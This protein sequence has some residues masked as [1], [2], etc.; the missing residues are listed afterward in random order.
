MNLSLLDPFQSGFPEVVEEYLEHGFA[1][2]IAFNR[3]GTLL[4]AGCADGASVIWDLDTRGVVREL[5]SERGASTAAAVTS[6]S[7]SKCGRKLLVASADRQLALWD[8]ERGGAPEV[9]LK[10]D[11]VALQAR[12]H[13]SDYHRCLVSPLGSPP[14]H[15]NLTSGAVRMLPTAES[16]AGPQAPPQAPAAQ[17]VQAVQGQAQAAAAVPAVFNKAG[18]LVYV[19]T[20]RGEVL[21]VG[22]ESNQV[23]AVHSIPGGACVRHLALSRSGKWLLAS[24]TDRVIRSYENKLHGYASPA[25]IT[26]D[27]VKKDVETI[28]KRKKAEGVNEELLKP[29]LLR[30]VKD[31]QDAVNR[32]H[33]RSACFSGDDEYVVG[34]AAGKGEHKIH[35]WNREFGQL[36]K[37]LEGP[38]EAVQDLAW[39]PTRP[40]AASVSQHSGVVFIWA[41]DYTENWSAFAPDFKE[42]EENEEYVEKEDEFDILPDEDKAKPRRA[43]EDE[44]DVMEVERVA[45]YSDSDTSESGLHYLAAVP[46]AEIPM[47][48]TANGN[49]K[50][51]TL[52]R[53]DSDRSSLDIGKI[54]HELPPQQR[55]LKLSSLQGA[56]PNT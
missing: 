55:T 9:T 48:L 27:L 20:T 8:V 43:D 25:A 16:P 41:K 40:I 29:V 44:V 54:Q 33:W 28:N 14:L 56:L 52:L 12:T 10:L 26:A 35:I 45:A 47:P 19:G 46:E 53:Q 3:R 4:A 34:A 5:C 2:C 38:K 51:D 23:Y 36:V 13:P 15:L 17:A 30:F 7:W 39:H 50:P 6:V 24:S 22:T 49:V 18:D 31:Y 42:L 37:I 32:P 11:A 1:R 21:V